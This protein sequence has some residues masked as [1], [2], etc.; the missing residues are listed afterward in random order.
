M[1]CKPRSSSNCCLS[2]RPNG[3][4][5]RVGDY[6]GGEGRGTCDNFL[7]QGEKVKETVKWKSGGKKK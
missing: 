5:R 3:K 1:P 7:S 6:H 4:P 2:D